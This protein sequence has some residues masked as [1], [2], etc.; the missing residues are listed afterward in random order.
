MPDPSKLKRGNRFFGATYEMIEG[1]SVAMHR[2]QCATCE[3]IDGITSGSRQELPMQMITKKFQQKG[4]EVGQVAR[5]DKCPACV[6]ADTAARRAKNNRHGNVVPIK[7]EEPAMSVQ[8][9][10]SITSPHLQ[11]V[12]AEPPRTMDV[13]ERR[14]I[15][16]KLQE[17]YIDKDAGYA[18]PWTDQAVA[19]DLGVPLAWVAD[20]RSNFFGPVRDNGEIRE[21]LD[22]IVIIRDE[23]GRKCDE[24][25]KLRKEGTEL[26]VRANTL[27]GSIIEL[28]RT[29]EHLVTAAGRIEKAL[30]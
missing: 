18:V 2:L 12:S 29:A 11:R 22:K 24:A 14:L 16:A 23:I 28:R 8:P 19:K 3:F 30:K 6:E 20:V 15:F 4:W 13:D 21:L 25:E 27:N 10:I 1:R 5:K 9:P 26:I 17:T 7:P